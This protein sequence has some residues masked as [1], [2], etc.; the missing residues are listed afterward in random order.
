MSSNERDFRRLIDGAFCHGDTAVIDELVSP[1]ASDHEAGTSPRGQGRERFQWV[2]GLLR[3][4]FPD[5][6]VTVEDIVTA[7]DKTWARVRYHGTHLG[8]FMGAAPTQRRA[9]WDGV[10]I[11]RWADGRL[12]EHWGV[13]DRLSGLQQLGLV[14]AA[15]AHH[16]VDGG[17]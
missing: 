15:G 1:E 4:A 9:E 8:R 13:V 7:G 17:R 16:E 5:L 12:V 3:T 6:E 10:S 2:V 14:S 11:C